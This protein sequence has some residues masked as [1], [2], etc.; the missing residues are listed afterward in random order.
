MRDQPQARALPAQETAPARHGREAGRLKCVVEKVHSCLQQARAERPR[1][2]QDLGAGGFQQGFSGAQ[3]LA[4]A[5]SVSGCCCL[6]WEDS[7]ESRSR[8]WGGDLVQNRVLP[9]QHPAGN[10]AH[11]SAVRV[12]GR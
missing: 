9:R 3:H 12:G 5:P 4:T 1:D 11:S 10:G 8:V 2:T 6:Y 7:S